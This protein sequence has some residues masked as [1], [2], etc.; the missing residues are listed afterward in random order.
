[1]VVFSHGGLILVASWV[2]ETQLLDPH[3]YKWALAVGHK[4]VL[5]VLTQQP[6]VVVVVFLHG[7]LMVASW[8]VILLKF[9]QYN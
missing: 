3:Q 5:V 9:F 1:M 4:S 2:L 8:V 6:F 7:G